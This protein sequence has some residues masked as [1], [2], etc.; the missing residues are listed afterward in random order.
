QILL[1]VGALIEFYFKL[2]I[3]I[4]IPEEPIL[5]SFINS[6]S[7]VSRSAYSLLIHSLIQQ[8]HIVHIKQKS[9]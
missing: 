1:S 6:L 9:P 4:T 7:E 2:I 3:C 8:R 5:Y